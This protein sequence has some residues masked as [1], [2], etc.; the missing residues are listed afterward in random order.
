MLLSSSEGEYKGWPSLNLFDTKLPSLNDFLS[1]AG[2]SKT[3]NDDWGGFC[4]SSRALLD[5]LRRAK[6]LGSLIGIELKPRRPLVTPEP[7]PEKL[8]ELPPASRVCK[9]PSPFSAVLLNSHKPGFRDGWRREG[10]AWKDS[11]PV[12]S[13]R[14]S[15]VAGLCVKRASGNEANDVNGRK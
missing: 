4:T 11:G 12:Q 9:N 8:S 5:D 3:R 7:L 1:P 15:V 6:P 2:R 13:A 14:V 10:Y